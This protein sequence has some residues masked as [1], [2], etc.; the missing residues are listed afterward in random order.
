MGIDH[1]LQTGET[2]KI[3]S[4]FEET[5]SKDFK[6]EFFRINFESLKTTINPKNKVNLEQLINDVISGNFFL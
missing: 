1:Y 3:E 5:Q 2:K 4:V 6:E